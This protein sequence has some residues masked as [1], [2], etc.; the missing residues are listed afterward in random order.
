MT[1]VDFHRRAVPPS[2]FAWYIA[3]NSPLPILSANAVEEGSGIADH[4][5]E[6]QFEA[7]A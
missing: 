7:A 2:V 1:E 5:V 3:P 4:H 6:E